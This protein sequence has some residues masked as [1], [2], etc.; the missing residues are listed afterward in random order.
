MGVAIALVLGSVTLRLP[1]GGFNDDAI[2]MALGRAISTGDGYRAIYLVGAPLHVKYPPLF[3]ALL[4]IC[5]RIGGSVDVVRSIVQVINIAACGGSAAMLWWLGRVRLGIPVAVMAAAT[6]VGF[7]LDPAVQYFTLV[8]SEPLFI[9]EWAAT[10]LLYERWRSAP[11][12]ARHRA[13]LAL[14]LALA[15]AALTRGQ[16][17]VLIPA[18]LAGLAL[19][20]ATKREWLIVA[21]ASVVPVSLWHIGLDVATRG[22]AVVLQGNE[23]AYLQFF[24]SGSPAVVVT[25]ELRS[26][27]GS[28]QGY[29]DMLSVL[30]G[31][32]PLIGKIAT[33]ILVLAFAFGA[34]LLERRARG[35]VL[36]TLATLAVVLAWPVSQDRF[37]VPLLPFAAAVAAYGVHRAIHSWIPNAT[38]RRVALGIVGL[39]GVFV[40]GRQVGIRREARTTN[41]DQRVAQLRTPSAWIPGNAQ[42][43]RSLANW[44]TTHTEPADRVVVASAAGLWLYSGRTTELTEFAEPQ[45]VPSTFAVPGR[46]LAGLLA[47]QRVTVVVVE[48]AS[49]GIARDVYVV[50]RRCPRSLAQLPGFPGQAMPVFFRA[51]PDQVCIAALRDSLRTVNVGPM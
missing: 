39:S 29:G 19:D 23:A 5:W 9:L 22:E 38:P 25:R 37:L 17:L 41:N 49:S 35:L 6:I 31:G 45:G 42:F 51:R 47:E 36:T 4:A 27:A 1:V 8:L 20:H 33:A 40:L 28:V 30:L 10:L 15:A 7:L 3:P 24:F 34:F 12:D 48:S 16:G 46:Y 32:W 44:V 50:H 43:V 13:A 2:Y 21:A 14:G 11:I 26:F 18:I